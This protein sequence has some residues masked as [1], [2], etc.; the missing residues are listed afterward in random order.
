MNWFEQMISDVGEAIE[1]AVEA[2]V[3]FVEDVVEVV[4]DVV[5]D[6]V[7]AVVDVVE[8][9]VDWTLNALDDT[10]F[11]TVDFITGGAIDVDYDDGQF[12]AGIDI[13]IASVGI[14]VGDQGFS[15]EAGFDIGVASGEISLDSADGFAASGSLGVEWGPLPYAEGHLTIGTDGSV[16]I[17]GEFQASLPLPFGEISFETSGGLERNPD[18]SWGAYSDAE[19][20]VDGAFGDFRLATDTSL[21]GDASGV[22]FESNLD[23]DASG[24]LGGRVGFDAGV[25]AGVTDGVAS[26]AADVDAEAGLLGAELRGGGSIAGSVAA[27]GAHDLSAE[28]RAGMSAGDNDIDGRAGLA[29]SVNSSGVITDVLTGEVI[30]DRDGS[31]VLAAGGD[32]TAT[33][34]LGAPSVTAE[35]WTDVVG[36]QSQPAVGS[37]STALEGSVPADSGAASPPIDDF[38]DDDFSDDSFGTDSL[39]E[40]TP[41]AF[42]P[43]DP[44]PEPAPVDEFS[45]VIAMADQAEEQADDLWDDI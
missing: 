12:S 36:D 31:T 19:L 38:S 5:E 16:S 34:G 13:G 18:G 26:L 22:R 42:A 15:A 23:V 41:E 37:S 2:V 43:S 14:S 7:E 17:G 6:V 1:D 44:T 4:V 25:A 11:D 27:D 10:V 24:P 9:V 8:D 3:D 20:N 32:V 29:H 30:V 21:E 35:G 33:H 39:G 45:S 28:V 40:P